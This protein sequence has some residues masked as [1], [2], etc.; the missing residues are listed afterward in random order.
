MR[1]LGWAALCTVCDVTDLHLLNR[2][3]QPSCT[4]QL[5]LQTIGVNIGTA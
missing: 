4:V 3:E 1:N 2:I 5:G